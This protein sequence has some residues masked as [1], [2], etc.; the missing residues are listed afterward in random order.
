MNSTRIVT[1][2]SPPAEVSMA[3]RWFE[4]AAID[5]FWTRRRFEVLRKLADGLIANARDIAEIGCGHGLLQLQIEDAY[6]REVT[7]FDLNEIALKQNVSRRSTVNCYDIYQRNPALSGKFDLIFLFDILEHIADEDGFLS[8]VLFHL[9]PGGSL[10]VNVPAGMWAYSAF[11][12]AVGHVRRYS[13]AS[14]RETAK[15]SDLEIKQSTYWGLP[16]VP[17]LLLRKLW[18]LGQ[19]DK[20]QIISKGFDS[21]G[22]FVNQIVSTISRCEPIPQELLGI[23]LMAILKPCRKCG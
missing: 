10:A 2:L 9:A 17:I 6:N 14:L 15:R 19:H 11:D 18:L 20:D 7:G 13:I 21:R 1:Y 3:D 4:V 8:A 16:L 5:H 22:K 12:V 23:A